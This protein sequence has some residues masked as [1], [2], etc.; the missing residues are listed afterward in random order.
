MIEKCCKNVVK[1]LQ[2]QVNKHFKGFKGS[3]SEMQHA[4]VM[5]TCFDE[6]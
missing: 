6:E 5:F 4:A 3:S 2:K 1:I